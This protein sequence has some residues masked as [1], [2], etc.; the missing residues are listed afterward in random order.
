MGKGKV[1]RGRWV[2]YER[3]AWK[4][5]RDGTTEGIC[6]RRGYEESGETVGKEVKERG[7]EEEK[8]NEW[9]EE[10][11][12]ERVET[13]SGT[14]R[15]R[16]TKRQKDGGVRARANETPCRSE[17]TREEERRVP[18]GESDRIKTGRVYRRTNDEE[19][20]TPSRE[21]GNG[22]GWM[23]EER[24]GEGEGRERDASYSAQH[25]R[26]RWQRLPSSLK[27]IIKKYIRGHLCFSSAS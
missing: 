22:Y 19:R 25:P 20:R 3:S 11:R 6:S 9:R 21:E 26:W 2:T 24:R 17:R 1:E 8:T 23:A 10:P 13:V 16:R 12:G 5:K 18:R 14:K 27:S 15:E 7:R 4:S